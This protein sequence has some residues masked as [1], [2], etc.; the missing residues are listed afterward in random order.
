[1]CVRYQLA[2][3]PSPR[4]ALDVVS[5]E[6]AADLAERLLGVDRAK[7]KLLSGERDRH[8]P[9]Y[10]CTPPPSAELPAGQRQ[11]ENDEDDENEADWE[12]VLDPFGLALIMPTNNDDDGGGM[13]GRL[14][15]FGVL[16]DDEDALPGNE[17]EMSS[18]SDDDMDWD[19][20]FDYED[21]EDENQ[22]DAD[23]DF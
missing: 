11:D 14:R 19:D 18:V 6:D 17:E 22:G 1:M 21:A 13:W 8:R 2:D 16:S 20:D 9:E 4:S 3:L 23:P 12:N 7:A 5:I 15:L 10:G